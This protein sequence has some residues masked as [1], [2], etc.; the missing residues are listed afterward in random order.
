MDIK[1]M[2]IATKS[3]TQLLDIT[4][5][6]EAYL[7]EIKAGAGLLTVFV[8]HTTA[9][10]TINENS[11]PAVARD[12]LAFTSGLVPQSGG[13]TH[14]EGNSDSH[15]KSSL[16]SPSLT[17]LVEHGRLRLGTWQAVYFAEFDGPRER[18]VWL[19]FVAG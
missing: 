13:F 8:P 12:I 1:E 15:I 14:A 18:K 10:V 6:I 7:R 9:G 16:F 4:G 3:R 5:E 17:C 19:K 2:E 11:D